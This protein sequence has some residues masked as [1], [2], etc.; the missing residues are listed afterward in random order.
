MNNKAYELKN[1]LCICS[2][3][4]CSCQ[5]FVIVRTKDGT[6]VGQTN[7]QIHG[8][9]IIDELNRL[10]DLVPSSQKWSRHKES[11]GEGECWTCKWCSHRHS[12]K[13]KECSDDPSINN[14][15][16]QD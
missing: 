6:S 3:I 10:H 8:Q 15:M 9:L 16:P 1:K 4:F 13:C 11:V 2:D 14:W 5:N 12:S 7:V